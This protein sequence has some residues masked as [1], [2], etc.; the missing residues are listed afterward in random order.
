VRQTKDLIQSALDSYGA[1]IEVTA[2]NFQRV[3]FPSE[4]QDAVQDAVK[5]R[6]DKEQAKLSAEKYENTVIPEARGE[7]QRQLEAA[8]AY[9]E[10]VTND[11]EGEAARFTALLKEYQAAPEVTRERLYID[12]I[13]YVYANSNKVFLDSDGEGNLLYLPV[14]KLLEQSSQRPR[15]SDNAS[16]QRGRDTANNQTSQNS[17]G[18]TNPRARRTR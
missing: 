14:D 15:A 13:E 17:N 3:D 16:L 5:A 18:A 8:E 10:R 4:V 7:A 6:E 9:K 12:A 2:V 1:G 11:A